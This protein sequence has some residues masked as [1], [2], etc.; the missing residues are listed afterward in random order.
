VLQPSEKQLNQLARRLQ[1]GD[2]SDAEYDREVDRLLGTALPPRDEATERA[3]ERR[4]RT[5]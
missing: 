4:R 2:L 1:E 5:R 3:W